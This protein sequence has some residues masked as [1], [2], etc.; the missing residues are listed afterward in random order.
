MGGPQ[1]R[2]TE[3]STGCE[4]KGKCLQFLLRLVQRMRTKW[5]ITIKG[6][7]NVKNMFTKFAV[8][9]HVIYSSIQLRPTMCLRGWMTF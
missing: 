2:S 7:K 4:E 8:A 3:S 5:G 1:Q 9:Q 6:L